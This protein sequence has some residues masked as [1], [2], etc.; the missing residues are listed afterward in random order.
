MQNEKIFTQNERFNEKIFSLWGHRP[1][2][3]EFQNFFQGAALGKL[4]QR[5]CW[6]DI[7]V[8]IRAILISMV[9]FGAFGHSSRLQNSKTI[10]FPKNLCILDQEI[11]DHLDRKFSGILLATT[12]SQFPGKFDFDF[13]FPISWEIGT[14][15][16]PPYH[17]T[18]AT[19]CTT[20]TLQDGNT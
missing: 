20:S 4:P 9:I 14:M 16:S 6:I 18:F 5:T 1:S 3:S 12:F 15:I 10:S 7:L 2:A 11:S 17:K 13:L 8:R 19:F